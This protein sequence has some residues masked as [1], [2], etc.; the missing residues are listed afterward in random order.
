MAAGV[1]KGLERVR[2]GSGSQ[3]GTQ[4]RNEGRWSEEWEWGKPGLSCSSGMA[5]LTSIL[6]SL[7]GPLSHLPA[8]RR[9]QVTL[10]IPPTLSLRASPG[11]TASPP[12][13]PRPP[14]LEQGCQL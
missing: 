14:H 9:A 1:E 11:D 13:E 6:E 4:A 12:L 8:R 5:S 7:P 3:V 10:Q 2:W